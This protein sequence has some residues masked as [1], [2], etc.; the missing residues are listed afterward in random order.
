MCVGTAR[1][2]VVE[3]E[4]AIHIVFNDLI[5]H[6]AFNDLIIQLVFQPFT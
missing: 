6:R 2:G 3:C 4:Q 5:I 1:G